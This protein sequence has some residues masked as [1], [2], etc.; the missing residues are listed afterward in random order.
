MCGAAFL[1]ASGAFATG[2]GMV[3]IV[4]PEENRIPLQTMLPEAM[5][6]CTD[7]LEKDFDWCD[8]LVIGPG[9]GMTVKAAD[10]VQFFLKKAKQEKKPVVLDADGLNLLAENPKWKNYLD[11][12]VILTPH[13]GEMSRLTGKSIREL[14]S[15]RAGAA[16]ALAVETG[17]V[18]VLKDAC[19]VTAAPDGRAWISLSGNAGMATAGSGDVLSGVLAGIQAMYPE[20]P[21]EEKDTGFYAALGVLLHGAGG[22]QAAMRK[23]MAGMKAGDIACGVA[24]ILKEQQNF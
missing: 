20:T 1:S 13:M 11:S 3:K 17:A 12:H 4:T 6:S 7:D 24:E 16:R 23:G 15:D 18:C 19:T 21:V 2:A 5:I 14:K 9:I 10:K 8:V 22:D